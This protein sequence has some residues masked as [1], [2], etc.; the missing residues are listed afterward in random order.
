M[1][2]RHQIR[3]YNNEVFFIKSTT[4]SDDIIKLEFD[5]ANYDGIKE[6]EVY[7]SENRILAF[8]LDRENIM[9]NGVQSFYILDNQHQIHQLQEDSKSGMYIE[10]E[11]NDLSK[12]SLA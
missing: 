7:Q 2:R 1:V 10:S 4:D 11:V 9:E 6:S 3:N 8:E 5:G 12:S